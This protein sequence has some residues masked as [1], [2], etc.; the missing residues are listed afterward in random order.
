MVMVTKTTTKKPVRRRKPKVAEPEAILAVEP[1]VAAAMLGPEQLPE[2][3]PE[4][5]KVADKAHKAA[6][7]GIVADIYLKT[8]SGVLMIAG[9]DGDAIREYIEQ[10]KEHS[11]LEYRFFD[12]D[13]KRWAYWAV[14]DGDKAFKPLTF[15]DPNQYNLTSLQLYTKAVTYTRV[16]AHAVG[17]LKEK[18]P[19]MWDRM[20]KPTTIIMAIVGIVFVMG[21]MLMALTG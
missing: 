19:T 8:T 1:E 11:P 7:P 17:L 14:Q 4:V 20:L 2:P 16:L 21:L 12:D 15:P 5:A 6:H 10:D 18:P 3:A 9:A 13:R